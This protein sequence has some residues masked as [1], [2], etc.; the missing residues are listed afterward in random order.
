MEG[1][2]EGRLTLVTRSPCFGLPTACPD[3]LSV[4][5]YLK[6]AHCTFD[7]YIHSTFPDSDQIPYVESG[8]YV[9]Y[10]NEKGGVIECLK[11]DSVIDLDSNFETIPEWISIKVM[12]G[13]WLMDAV[14]YELWVGSEGNSAQKI[15]YSD[16]PWPIGKILYYKQVHAA[17]QLLGITKENAERR[18]AEIYRRAG[19]AYEALSTRLGADPYF[20]GRPTS[21]DATFLGHA[22]FTL[23]AL[24]ETSTLRSKLLNHSNLIKYTETHSAELIEADGSSSSTVPLPKGDPSSSV[25]KP[26]GFANWNSKPK[27]KPKREKTEEEKKFRRRAKYFLAAQL[28]AVLVFLSLLGGSDDAEMELEEDDEGLNY[29]D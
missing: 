15:F 24:P 7:I 20:F 21:L 18:E 19:I 16:L 22:L 10:N 27:S 2:K 25:P 11:E 26:G 8:D 9:A 6:F 13:S 17:K 1:A 3:G 28:V 4:Y 23:Q 5:F 12:V 14:M 29:G